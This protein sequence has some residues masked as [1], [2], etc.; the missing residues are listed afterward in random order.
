MWAGS[1]YWNSE[2]KW[3]KKRRIYCLIQG[4]EEDGDLDRE[5]ERQ[6]RDEKRRE[7]REKRKN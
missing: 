2:R 4:K 1:V 6:R 7:E 5:K 3:K